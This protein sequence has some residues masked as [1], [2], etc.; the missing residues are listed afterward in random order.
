M[1]MSNSIIQSNN[2]I[3]NTFSLKAELS[4]STLLSLILKYHFTG[5]LWCL[6]ESNQLAVCPRLSNC[7]LVS[8]VKLYRVTQGISH[9]PMIA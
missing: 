5:D 7:D 4:F 9:S 3:E 1:Q 2:K 6:T 8:V